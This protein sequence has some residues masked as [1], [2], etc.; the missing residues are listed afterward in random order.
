MNLMFGLSGSKTTLPSSVLMLGAPT[1]SS[2]AT[3]S[4][5]GQP[6]QVD[7]VLVRRLLPDQRLA[8]PTPVAGRQEGRPLA[9]TYKCMYY[10]KPFYKLK[11]MLFYSSYK[12]SFKYTIPF[13]FF[14]VLYDLILLNNFFSPHFFR[15]LKNN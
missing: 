15:C 13:F 6:V 3:R 2:S 14:Y 12:L 11:H 1:T 4:K 9:T 8:L 5:C 7:Q 10:R